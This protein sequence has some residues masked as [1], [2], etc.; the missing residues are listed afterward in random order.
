KKVWLT[1]IHDYFPI[2]LRWLYP[3]KTLRNKTW[4]P[5][6]KD[7]LF[8]SFTR[9]VNRSSKAPVHRTHPVHAEDT[10]LLQYTGGTTGVSK[11]AILTHRNLVANAYQCRAWFWMLMEGHEI[12][13]VAVPIFHC[14]GMTVGMNTAI[15]FGSAMVLLPRFD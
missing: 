14:Y 1:R 8:A 2:P 10:A 5:W 11:G 13:L 3:L 7:P 12:F 9:A 4:V 15:A 6:P